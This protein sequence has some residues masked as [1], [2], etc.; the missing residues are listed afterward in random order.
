MTTEVVR[1][2]SQTDSSDVVR[3]AARVLADGGLVAFPTETVYGLA[4]CVRSREGVGRLRALKQRPGDKAFTVHIGGRDTATEFV[5]ELD[6][7]ANRLIRKAWPGPLTLILTVEHPSRVPVTARMDANEVAT[8]FFNNTVGLRCPDDPIAAALLQAVDGP[9][10][11][12][13]ANLAGKTPPDT[14]A[15]VLRQLDGRIDLLIDCGRTRYAKPSTI[16]RVNGGVY[17]LLREGVYDSRT[18]ERLSCLRVLFVCTGNTCR[19]PM[20][21]SLA[22]QVLA[23]RLACDISELAGRRVIVNSAGTAGGLG[24]ASAHAIEVMSRRG[25]D[26]SPHS[27]TSVTAEMVAEADHIFVMT[28]AHRDFVVSLVPSSKD[29][30]ALLWGAEDI[31]DPI[32]G[33]QDDYESCAQAIEKGVQAR[34]QEV[35]I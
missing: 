1:V 10:V 5:P 14:G 27:S 4:A 17:E 13:S 20:A 18:I 15:A 21:A 11:A 6:G 26:I 24:G 35:C 9:V 16:V 30:T 23:A 22:R 32:G 31:Q 29:R 25:I 33:T 12:A 8:I 19:S 3:D 2:D 28:R 34:L 7:L